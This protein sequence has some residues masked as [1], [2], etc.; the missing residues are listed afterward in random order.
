MSCFA[1]RGASG[2][3][4][5]ERWRRSPIVQ[6]MGKW[7]VILLAVM[8]G[9]AVLGFLVEAARI[10]AGALF[11]GCLLVLAGRFLVRRRS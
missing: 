3:L 10:I 1:W 2:R 11:V 6:L 7:I 5:P 4:A 8:A 9:L